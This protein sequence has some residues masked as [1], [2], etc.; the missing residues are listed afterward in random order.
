[1]L[2]VLVFVRQLTA[3]REAR[4]LMEQAINDGWGHAMGDAALNAIADTLRNQLASPAVIGRFGGDE[5]VA[6]LVGVP[7][8]QVERLT[9]SISTFAIPV[10]GTDGELVVR[11]TA[12]SATGRHSDLDQLVREADRML[13]QRRATARSGTPSSRPVVVDAEE[14]DHVTNIR[15]ARNAAGRRP[16][17]SVREHRVSLDPAVGAEFGPDAPGEAEVRRV[18]PVDVA[19]LSPPDDERHLSELSGVDLDAGPGADLGDDLLTRGPRHRR[20]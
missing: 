6:L 14:L 11:V 10:P 19:D 2:T 4:V 8:S 16:L 9:A 17:R 1:M 18:V 15:V 5:F 12:G 20:P 13:Y 3:D 7:A